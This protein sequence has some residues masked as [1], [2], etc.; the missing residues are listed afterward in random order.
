MQLA[1]TSDKL[2]KTILFNAER[3]TAPV[4]APAASAYFSLLFLKSGHGSVTLRTGREASITMALRAPVAICLRDQETATFSITDGDVYNLVFSPTF[5]NVNMRP[6]VMEEDVYMMLA[7]TYRL[8]RL[9]PFME[10]H[11]ELK[12]IEMSDE[13]MQNYFSLCDAA[14]RA[15]EDPDPDHCWSCRIR[16]SLM[17]ILV[18]LETQYACRIRETGDDSLTFKTYRDIV[19]RIHGDLAAPCRIEDVCRA[20]GINKNKLQH[21][22]RL[23]SGLSYYEFIKKARLERAERYLA[24]TGLKLSEISCR[25]G[26][27]TE[28][29]FYRFFRRETGIAPMIFRRTTV[30]QRKAA[31]SGVCASGSGDPG[32]VIHEA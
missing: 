22:F 14:V 2:R 12:L 13:Q 15:M 27:S 30:A 28:Q 18:G 6:A 16:A 5:I 24:F 21:I 9:A 29:H 4:T 32:C 20:F 10:T 31:F 26:F 1:R 8:F 7:E 25:L 11:A 17:D 3:S 19:L 23:Y